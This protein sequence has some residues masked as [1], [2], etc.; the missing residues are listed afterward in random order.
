[1]FLPLFFSFSSLLFFSL[2]G[3]KWR[4]LE[5]QFWCFALGNMSHGGA[6]IRP[7]PH[8]KHCEGA[9]DMLIGRR[10]SSRFQYLKLFLK[11]ET[12]SHL[13]DETT[14]IFKVKAAVLRPHKGKAGKGGV[15]GKSEGHMQCSGEE[16]N[17]VGDVFV[18]SH[19]GMLRLMMDINGPHTDK[20]AGNKAGDESKKKR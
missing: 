19:K 1:M 12:G 20:G 16:L 8:A 3:G 14:E 17:S 13:S 10:A 18:Q 6:D 5:G 11:M 15:E 2:G 4:R 9:L 7:T